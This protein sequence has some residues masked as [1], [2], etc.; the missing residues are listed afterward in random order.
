LSNPAAWSELSLNQKIAGGVGFA[1]TL[2][3]T[4]FSINDL[5]PQ[6]LI[7]SPSRADWAKHE[8]KRT[9]IL[10][11][12]GVAAIAGA[13]VALTS[14]GKFA[15]LLFGGFMALLGVTTF[16][17]AWPDEPPKQFSDSPSP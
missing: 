4:Y 5:F 3:A 2:V 17:I 7:G 15:S 12:S 16:A 14:Q 13:G 6:G 1:A 10:V 9:A 8:T 11:S